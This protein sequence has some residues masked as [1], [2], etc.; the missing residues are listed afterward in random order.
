NGKERHQ[1]EMRVLVMNQQ[2]FKRFLW[3]ITLF[4]VIYFLLIGRLAYIQLWGTENFSSRGVNLIKKSVQ[5]R[6]QEFVLHSGRG[7][8][9]DRYGHPFT[10]LS[11]YVF[12]MF[13]LMNKTAISKQKLED[14]ATMLSVTPT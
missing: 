13:P 7:E 8:I 14:L 1:E 5:Q 6:Q 11:T 2:V 3:I 9:T 10:G 4:S 12:T